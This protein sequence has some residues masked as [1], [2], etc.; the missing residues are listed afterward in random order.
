MANPLAVLGKARI[1]YLQGQRLG[2]Q[3]R[4]KQEQEQLAKQQADEE[5]KLKR[6]AMEMAL[7]K[8]ERE[9]N[10]PAPPRNID[11]YSPEGIA[12]QIAIAQG[13]PAPTPAPRNIDP[14]SKEGIAAQLAVAQGKPSGQEKPA[15]EGERATGSFAARMEAAEREFANVGQKGAPTLRTNVAASVPLVGERLERMAQSPEQQIARTASDEWIRAKLRK[16]SGAAISE[17][18]RS[19]EYKT[20][21]PLEGDLPATVALKGRLRATAMSEMKRQAGAGYAAGRADMVDPKQDL[22]DKWDRAAV[23]L[24]NQGKTEQEI[25]AILK[26]P[27][28]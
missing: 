10:A 7:L 2:E 9:L 5:M 4:A 27:R 26:G 6:R 28:P 25:I 20:Y 22:R 3:D 23:H 1:G 12:A 19:R 14:L 13:R 24:S 11:P 8:S 16:E 15:T 18:E 21:F 17:D